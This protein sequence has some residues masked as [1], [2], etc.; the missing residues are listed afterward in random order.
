MRIK[1]IVR[2]ALIVSSATILLGAGAVLAST[3]YGKLIVEKLVVHNTSKFEGDVTAKGNVT[4]NGDLSVH[5]NAV[6]QSLSD[7]LGTTTSTWSGAI[8]SVWSGDVNDTADYGGTAITVTFTPTDTTAGTISMT[9]TNIFYPNDEPDTTSSDFPQT[10]TADYQLAGNQMFVTGSD[11]P[12]GMFGSGSI[13]V[14]VLPDGT[15]S[16]ENHTTSP[17]PVVILTKT[18]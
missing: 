9:P 3:S 6:G 5:G 7:V 13:N 8:Y 18:S 16:F 14:E 17:V 11:S 1:H 10:F 2:N 4:I 12:T 15:L